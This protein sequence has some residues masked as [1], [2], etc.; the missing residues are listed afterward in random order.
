[1]VVKELTFINTGT[2][3]TGIVIDQ[4]SHGILSREI[5]LLKKCNYL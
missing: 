5:F 1:M 4:I 2:I 3:A